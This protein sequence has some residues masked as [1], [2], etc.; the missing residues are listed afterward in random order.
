[1]PGA[2]RTHVLNHELDRLVVAKPDRSTYDS[3]S[4]IH[5]VSESSN[6][7]QLVDPPSRV[8]EPHATCKLCADDHNCTQVSAFRAQLGKEVNY[9]EL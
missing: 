9:D 5:Q 1:M 8:I 7:A 2:E 4:R 3:A 6:S